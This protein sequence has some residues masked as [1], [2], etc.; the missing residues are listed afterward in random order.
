VFALSGIRV[1]FKRGEE[2]KYISHLDLMKAFERALRRSKLPVAYSEGFNPH[3]RMV[4][5]LPLSV[6]VTSDA[7]YADFEFSEDISARE[8]IETLNPQLPSGLAVT[9]AVEKT[10]RSNIM[11][12]IARASYCV[13][14]CTGNKLG[15]NQMKRLIDDLMKKDEIKINKKTKS[16]TREIDIKPMIHAIDVVSTAN[17]SGNE[18]C[19]D[20]VYK[21]STVLS[22]GSRGNLKPE[23]VVEA[24]SQMA[25]EPVRILSI[26]R[27]G[28]YIERNGKI[29]EPLKMQ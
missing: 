20:N 7:E 8:L 12:E 27:T 29:F 5:G 18:G 9:D 15:I 23:E 1:R 25:G 24:V 14:V 11:A 6:G 19:T 13:N 10:G 17:E 21:I 4:F 2:V 22:A 16:G 3:P 28:L 26:H